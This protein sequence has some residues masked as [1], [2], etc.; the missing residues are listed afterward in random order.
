MNG[1]KQEKKRNV[2]LETKPEKSQTTRTTTTEARP[3]VPRMNACVI[4]AGVN[5]GSSIVMGT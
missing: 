3:Y 1:M 4:M 5:P 2:A